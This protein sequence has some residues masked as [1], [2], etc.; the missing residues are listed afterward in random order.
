[1]FDLGSL[2]NGTSILVGYLMQ[3][4]SLYKNSYVDKSVQY[5]SWRYKFESESNSVSGIMIY[6]CKV[7]LTDSML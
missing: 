7:M 2:F 1:M 3:K 4:P 6:I 5:L